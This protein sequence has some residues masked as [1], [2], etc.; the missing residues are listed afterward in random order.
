MGN[1]QSYQ[2][3]SYNNDCNYF[4]VKYNLTPS[5]PDFGYKLIDLKLLRQLNHLSPGET[6]TDQYIDLR[7]NFSPFYDAYG[8]EVFDECSRLSIQ[9]TN[10]RFNDNFNTSPE[11]LISISYYMDYLGFFGYQQTTDLFFQEA[12]TFNYGL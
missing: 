12:G 4:N 10:R 5:L 2:E 8:I 3:Y 7:N 9:Y 11:E 1:S 6:I